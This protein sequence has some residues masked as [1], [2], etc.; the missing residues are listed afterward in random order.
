[1]KPLRDGKKN[2]TALFACVS[3][4]AFGSD[5]LSTLGTVPVNVLAS[6]SCRT[7]EYTVFPDDGRS[8][9]AK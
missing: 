7:V 8:G 4:S 1:M 6:R 9:V 2:C 3:L 5:G